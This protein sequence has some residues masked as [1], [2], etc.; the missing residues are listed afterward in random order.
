LSLLPRLGEAFHTGR[1][2]TFDERGP[3]SAED[4]ELLM[5]NWYRQ[6]LVTTALPQSDG[7]IDRLREGAVVADVGCG[8]GIAILEMAR[9]FPASTFHDYDVSVHGRR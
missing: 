8:S 6:V 2:L 9:A 5:G 4:G 7:V 1:G 3:E